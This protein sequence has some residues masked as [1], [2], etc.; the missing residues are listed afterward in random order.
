M[1]E[2]KQLLDIIDKIKTVLRNEKFV[3]KPLN[4]ANG[5]IVYSSEKIDDN[6]NIKEYYASYD[7][8]E[9]RYTYRYYYYEKFENS[10]SSSKHATI[11]M[12][13]PAFANSQKPDS[14]IK[15]IKKYLCDVLKGFGSFDIVNLYPIRMPKSVCL[16]DLLKVLLKV[17]QVEKKADKKADKYQKFVESYLTKLSTNYNNIIIAAWGSKNRDN[18]VAKDL[19]KDSKIKLHCYGLTKNH[20]PRHFASQSY[21]IWYKNT[22]FSKYRLEKWKIYEQ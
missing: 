9:E 7:K 19:L 18:V 1:T 17:K 5:F 20:F 11:V 2:D 10:D 12:M 3:V 21:N 4:Y 8:I 15:N 16:D 14:T 6:E 22:D 13:N